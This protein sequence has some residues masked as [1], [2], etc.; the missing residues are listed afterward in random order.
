MTEE[1]IRAIIAEEVSKAIDGEGGA[2][3]HCR[4]AAFNMLRDVMRMEAQ[5]TLARFPHT[6]DM[7]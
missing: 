3:D 5:Q 4:S 7:N 1:Q 6:K 2:L